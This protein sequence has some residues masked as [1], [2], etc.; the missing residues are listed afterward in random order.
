MSKANQAAGTILREFFRGIGGGGVGDLLNA[1]AFK[2]D[3]PTETVQLKMF[4][5]G[6]SGASDYGSRVRGYIHPPVSGLYV[7]WISADDQGELKLSMD[8]DPAHAKTIASVPEWCGEREYTK[9]AQQKSQPI[10]LKAGRRYYIEA[11]HKQGAGG[12]HVSVIWSLPNGTEER[13]IPGNRLSP[14]IR[15]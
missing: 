11:L 9:H 6:Q 7:F 8:E 2:D 13:P 4:E 10:E 14:Y 15:K 3:K 5:A 1:Q 12:D